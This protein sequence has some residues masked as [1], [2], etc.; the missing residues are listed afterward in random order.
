[1]TIRH[2]WLSSCLWLGGL[3][4]VPCAMACFH[5]FPAGC[6]RWLKEK[7][8]GFSTCLRSVS[9]FCV[10]FG[11]DGVTLRGILEIVNCYY[12]K[13]YCADSFDANLCRITADVVLHILPRKWWVNIR[14]WSAVNHGVYFLY[15]IRLI[16]TIQL[17]F[18]VVLFTVDLSQKVHDKSFG[19]KKNNFYQIV[20]S[21]NWVWM[22]LL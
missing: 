7:S 8:M 14:E 17:Y 3:G 10:I 5:R 2:A 13:W 19:L 20:C 18:N 16:N 15:K 6:C 22:K 9:V 11:R 21:T 4:V 1:M 12:K